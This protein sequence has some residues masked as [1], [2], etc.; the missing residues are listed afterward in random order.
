MKVTI[1]ALFFTVASAQYYSKPAY[2]APSY[3]PMPYNFAWGVKDDASY[4]NYAHSESSD[5][6]VVTGS[7]RVALP[8]GRTQIVYYRADSNGYV[9]DVKYE[10]EARYPENKPSYSSYSAPAYKAPSAPVYRAP[11]APAYVAPRAP[12][13]G[14]VQAPS[15]GSVSAPAYKAPPAP[16]YV[17]PRVPAYSAP[18]TQTYRAATAT[19]QRGSVAA[20]GYNTQQQ[21][22]ISYSRG[23]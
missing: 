3:S 16:A 8:D 15:Y 21:W 20:P 4:N 13:Y 5:G 12:T 23:G 7:Y 22:P 17:A 18:K 11:A 10:G 19:G 14:S 9:A 6:N 2:S 1:L